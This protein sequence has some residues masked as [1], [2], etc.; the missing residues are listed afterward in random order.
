MEDDH[1]KAEG[2]NEQSCILAWG[3]EGKPSSSLR[4]QCA[5][6]L[7]PPQQLPAPGQGRRDGGLRGGYSGEQRE[8]TV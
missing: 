4:L 6:L 5:V 1:R 8:L 2:E 3:K 7:H